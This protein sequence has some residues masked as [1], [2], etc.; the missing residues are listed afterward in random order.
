MRKCYRRSAVSIITVLASACVAGG[1]PDNDSSNE[2]TGELTQDLDTCGWGDGSYVRTGHFTRNVPGARL[3]VFS[4]KKGT[5]RTYLGGAPFVYKPYSADDTWGSAGLTW[6]GDFTG[7]G[8]SDLASADGDQVYM[9]ISERDVNEGFDSDTWAVPNAWGTSSNTFAADFTGDGKTDIA[10]IVGG[11]IN[12]NV[13]TGSGFTSGPIVVSNSWGV[14]GYT[15]AA[16]F[17]GDGRADLAS[18]GSGSVQ[19]KISMKDGEVD[20]FDSTAWSVTNTWGTAARTWVADFD[21]NGKADFASASGGTIYMKLSNGS[22]FTSETRTVDNTWGSSSYT[23]VADFNDDGLPDIASASG[24][25]IYMKLSKKN[26]AGS[27]DGFE[28]ETWQINS[29]WGDS[30]FTR[31]GDFTGDG[32]ADIVTFNGCMVTLHRSTGTSFE[33]VVY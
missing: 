20:T 8:A 26:A 27:W 22:G 28:S 30:Q 33:T 13:S 19:M 10:S 32:V 31:V 14:A 23:W 29:P 1:D 12:Y 16:D 9:K 11:T 7:D 2:P 6:V 4:P 25:N 5:V 15:F 3:D 17:T 18:G 21:G 24:N